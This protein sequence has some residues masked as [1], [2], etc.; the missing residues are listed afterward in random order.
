MISDICILTFSAVGALTE[1]FCTQLDDNFA[2][3]VTCALTGLIWF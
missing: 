3:P 1:L 2:I